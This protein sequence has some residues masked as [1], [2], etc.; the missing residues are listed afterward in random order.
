MC[1]QLQ[2]RGSRL[3]KVGLP[4]RRTAGSVPPGCGSARPRS[5]AE[6]APPT[7]P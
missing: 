3:W 6:S 7:R 5:R 1:G 4:G 2:G